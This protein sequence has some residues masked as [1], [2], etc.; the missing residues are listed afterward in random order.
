MEYNQEDRRTEVKE[1]IAEK[2]GKVNEIKACCM[3]E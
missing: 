2:S 3:K 1:K